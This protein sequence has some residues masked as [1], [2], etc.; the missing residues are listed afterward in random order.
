VTLPPDPPEAIATKLR[1]VDALRARGVSLAE[2][3]G[4]VALV[5][6]NAGAVPAAQSGPAGAVGAQVEGLEADLTYSLFDAAQA[7]GRPWAARDSDEVGRIARKLKGL[8][9]RM[10]Q[11][12]G[13]MA[14]ILGQADASDLAAHARLWRLQAK[15]LEWTARIGPVAACLDR[16]AGAEAVALYPPPLP[17]GDL[18][19]TAIELLAGTLVTLDKRLNAEPQDPAMA[20]RGSYPD[21]RLSPAAFVSHLHAAYRVVRAQRRVPPVR[22]LDVGCGG[23]VKVLMA[24]SLFER[25]EGIELDPGYAAAAR[26]LLDVLAPAAGVR[27]ADALTFEGYGDYEV[28]YFYKPFRDAAPLMDLERRIAARAR[29]GTL[30]IAPYPEFHARASG[31]GCAP[32]AGSLFLAGTREAEARAVRE[33]A[34][35]VGPDAI[36]PPDQ[37]RWGAPWQVLLDALWAEGYAP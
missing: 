20:A 36:R 37:A 24:E 5:R 25:C 34:E 32:V 2:A 30:L 11:V 18:Q 28:V 23:G 22:F 35:R 8:P 21:I 15:A 33:A 17:R 31:L 14:R 10:T 12:L 6:T 27:E 3:L 29:P 7:V 1:Q 4:R 9:R 26:R 16:L 19:A 13:G